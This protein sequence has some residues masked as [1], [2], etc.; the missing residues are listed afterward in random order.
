[1][2]ANYSILVVD[3][4]P[5]L[6]TTLAMILQKKGYKV[7]PVA[8]PHDALQCL[9]SGP[10]DLAF[11]DLQ[12]PDMNGLVLLKEIRRLQP[13]MP[14]IILTAHASLD[15]AIEAVRQGARDYL[16]KPIDPAL[17]LARVED[18]LSE[19]QQS[20]K[21]REI[22]GQVQALLE[23]LQRVDDK[24]GTATPTLLPTL[25][26]ASSSRFLRRGPFTLDLHARHA[27]LHGKLITLPPI[28][29]DYLATLVRHAPNPVNHISLVMQSQG[30]TLSRIEAQEHT[31]WRI[32][33]LRNILETD[34]GHPKYI[35][36]VH[37]I[38]YRLAA[39]TNEEH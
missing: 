1:V 9:T 29:F 6:R 7:T 18:I 8:H 19:R 36:T 15:S 14:V 27:L 11:I 28:S 21:K 25:G 2:T 31:R 13:E 34:P 24:E 17:I 32:H 22:V 33:E 10:F 5:K 12:M 38:G 37:G 26:A 30:Y 23:E 4:E 16:I 35:L 3:D 39:E 20:Q